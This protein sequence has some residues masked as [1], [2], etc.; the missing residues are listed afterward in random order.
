[1]PLNQHFH[2]QIPEDPSNQGPKEGL[3]REPSSPSGTLPWLLP[4]HAHFHVGGKKLQWNSR[5]HRK[6]RHPVEDGKRRRISRFFWIEWWNISWWVAF[7]RSLENWLIMIVVYTW[8]G[9]LGYQR[10]FGIFTDTG[11]GSGSE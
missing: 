10:I 1:M 11:S 8:V 9:S 7:V 4:T 3:T 5:D 2:H 6:G